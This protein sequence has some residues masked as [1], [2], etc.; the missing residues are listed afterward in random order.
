MKKKFYE[1]SGLDII[2]D[3]IKNTLVFRNKTNTPNQNT[4]YTIIK[5]KTNDGL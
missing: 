3:N 4:W 1:T 5:N 2:K